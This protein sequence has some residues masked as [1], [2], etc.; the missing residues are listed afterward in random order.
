MYRRVDLLPV[1]A[2]QRVDPNRILQ[3]KTMYP[4]IEH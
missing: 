4:E 1:A 3:V 2:V